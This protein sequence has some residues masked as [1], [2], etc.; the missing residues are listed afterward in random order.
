MPSAMGMG[1]SPAVGAGSLQVVDTSMVEIKLL[2]MMWSVEEQSLRKALV[3]LG[4]RE[5]F[6][7]WGRGNTHL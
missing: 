4:F 1:T 2:M 7:S 5:E 6:N 3:L